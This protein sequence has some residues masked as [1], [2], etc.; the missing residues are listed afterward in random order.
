MFQV[1]HF[2]YVEKDTKGFFKTDDLF[3]KNK[4]SMESEEN[5]SET[6]SAGDDEEDK[7][8]VGKRKKKGTKHGQ[9]RGKNSKGNRL[10]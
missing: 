5:D 9:Q 10:S 1:I 7:N 3:D 2:V 8:M 6:A 4:D